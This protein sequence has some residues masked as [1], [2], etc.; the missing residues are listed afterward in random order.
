MKKEVSPKWCWVNTNW[1][2]NILFKNHFTSRVTNNLFM[3]KDVALTRVCLV[4]YLLSV[5]LEDQQIDVL[6]KPMHFLTLDLKKKLITSE[7]TLIRMVVY[8][9]LQWKV[10][11]D[12]F[13][14]LTLFSMVAIGKEFCTTQNF[15]QPE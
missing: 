14:T 10:E 13:L 12:F 9:V 5:R 3:R 4:K 15:L 7:G 1:Y 8:K 2:T 11:I 6:E